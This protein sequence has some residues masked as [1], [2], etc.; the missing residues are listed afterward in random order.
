[1]ATTCW[2]PNVRSGSHG[3]AAAHIGISAPVIVLNLAATGAGRDD[4][5]FFNPRVTAVSETIELGSEASVSMPGVALQ[6][7]R[8]VWAELDYQDETGQARQ[9]RLEGFAARCALHEIDQVNGVFFLR[10]VSRLKR[11]AAIKRY[12][13]RAQGG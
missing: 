2:P 1:M 12:R 11:E 3:L 9:A 8:P 5:L 13:K 4:V 10:R 7:A 6:V